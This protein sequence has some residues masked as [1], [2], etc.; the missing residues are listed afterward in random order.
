M[1]EGRGGGWILGA[2]LETRRAQAEAPVPAEL[3]AQDRRCRFQL[4]PNRLPLQAVV[5][6]GSAAAFSSL[7]PFEAWQETESVQTPTPLTPS[8]AFSF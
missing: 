5:R 7:A 1:S 4:A 3:T 6:E 2:W 8:P